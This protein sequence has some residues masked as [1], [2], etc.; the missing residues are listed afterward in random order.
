MT[1]AF[2]EA[3]F[4]NA[5]IALCKEELGYL[6][7]CGYDIERDYKDCFYEDSLLSSLAT[8]N[9][10]IPSAA[11]ESAIFTIK[12]RLEGTLVQK[13][14]QFHDYLQNGVEVSIQR[15]GKTEYHN[16]KLIDFDNVD[17]NDYIIANQWTI[18]G[19]DNKRP[20]V[21]VFINGIPL[22]VMEL[23]SCSRAQTDVS[24]AYLQ[25]RNYMQ[26][27]P[28]LFYYNAFCIIS[29]M[30]TTKAGTITADETRYMAWKTIDGKSYLDNPD[31]SILIK[32]MLEKARLLD[33][34]RNFIVF[35][36]EEK[37]DIKILAAYHQYFAVK[38][39]LYS[40]LSAI[41]TTRKGGVFWHTQGSGKSLSMLFLTHL[42]RNRL[43]NPT[44]VVLTD[45]NDLDKQLF[46]QFAK[47][48]DF[49]R[50]EPLNAESCEE[51]TE[52]LSGTEYGGIY[53]STMQK[54][55]ETEQPFSMRD[56]IIILADEA[57]RSQYGL[58]ERYDMKSQKMKKGYARLIREALPNATFVGFTGTPIST[59]DHSTIE[60]FGDT[61]DVY[62]MTQ[63]VK[64]GATRPV[65]Y[66]SRVMNLKLDEDVLK[67]IDDKIMQVAEDTP[68]FALNLIKTQKQIAT[69]ESLLNN[70]T[71]IDTLVEDII[72]HYEERKDILTGKAMI[73]AYSRAIAIS[74]YKKILE[75]RPDWD[76]KVKVVMTGSN[77]DPEEW[78]SI[79]GGD[80]YKQEL[81]KKF[82][83]NEDPMKIA[84]VVDM[85]LT[86]FDVPSLATMYVFKPMAGHNLMQAIAR[87]NRVFKDKEGGLVVDYIGIIGALKL[88]MRDFTKRD[89]DHYGNMDISR[90]A[91]IEFRD[92]LEVCI[93]LFYGFDINP[94]ITGNDLQ[95]ANAITGGLNFILGQPEQKKQ[96]M[97]VAYQLRQASSLCRS[98]QDKVERYKAAFFETLRVSITRLETGKGSSGIV[99]RN[100][101]KEITELLNQSVQTLG[102]INLFDDFSEE[103]S[104]LD[105]QF[106]QDVANMKEKNIASELLKKLLQDKIHQYKRSNLVKST[107]FSKKMEEIMNRWRNM[108]ITNAE[109]IEELLKLANEIQKDSKEAN[110]LG[111]SEEEKAFYD[112]LTKP[113]A[114][115]DFYENDE[116]VAMTKELT[117]TLRKNKSID[118]N[119]KD[120]ARAK[121]RML[122]KRLLKKYK[123]PPEAAEG[124]LK[125]VLEQCE[126]WTDYEA[127]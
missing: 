98:M 86:G 37:G 42:L 119:R 44:I 126:L 6:H 90:T 105:P 5:L 99:L 46:L 4:E 108:Q 34:I 54:F 82:K 48:K 107:L 80:K 84:I 58:D 70:P 68:E 36:K 61:I 49:L 87:V 72:K 29:D 39:A 41:G 77:Q 93:K 96:F 123:Y 1:I 81:A 30:L 112:A 71:T 76:E 65:Y 32:G 18:Q 114:V 121:M 73:I 66:E 67:N 35:Q 111:L 106:L 113:K 45:R 83:D 62:D 60:V 69:M 97:E 55:E 17:K 78:H 100:L 51:L 85:W 8:I 43:T 24:D 40:T 109:V 38:K 74:I 7:I 125:V 118:W 89:N 50:T 16:V 75:L 53:F 47:C 21:I 28:K 104:L 120:A 59:K 102:V 124:A 52:L 117:D 31:Y 13:N 91:L 64:D 56:N 92:K 10:G 2:N 79:I 23:K 22:V 11:I 57:H 3:V 110:S 26:I 14:H 101:S 63:S 95:R 25:I 33:I 115:R 127:I 15:N 94:F 9:P 116:L 19:S 122:V 20:D 103:F 88:A 12:N 27:I